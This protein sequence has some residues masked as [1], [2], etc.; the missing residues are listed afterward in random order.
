MNQ[1]ILV[2]ENFKANMPL[3]QMLVSNKE[4]I[5]MK[6]NQR[7]PLAAIN[8]KGLK[9]EIS[10]LMKYKDILGS[11]SFMKHGRLENCS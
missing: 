11:T 10:I 3:L 7:A 1:R 4:R 8:M 9:I 6:A 5:P 2:G